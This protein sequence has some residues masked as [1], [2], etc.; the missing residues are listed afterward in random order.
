MGKDESGGCELCARYYRDCGGRLGNGGNGL[1]FGS[2]ISLGVRFRI[3]CSMREICYDC[4]L[5]CDP[6]TEKKPARKIRAIRKR[7]P[8]NVGSAADTL[9]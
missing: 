8:G 1:G 9:P 2:D 6:D 7:N 3:H 5:D 4:D